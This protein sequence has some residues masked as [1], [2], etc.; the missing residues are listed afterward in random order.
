MT[1]RFEPFDPTPADDDRLKI[2][3]GTLLVAS[4]AL[5]GTVFQ[6]AVVFVLQNN[7]DGTF[8]VVLNRPANDEIKV[9]WHKLVGSEFSDRFIVQ[10]GPI[11]GPVF[12]LHQEQNLAEMEIPGGVFVSAGSDK[13]Q[14]LVE[15]D[16]SSYRIVFGVAGW[17]HGQLQDEIDDG[18]WFPLDGDAAQ[19]FDDPTWMWEKTLRRYGQELICDIVGLDRLP[20]SPLLN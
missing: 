20:A 16:D 12:A 1:N 5:K 17:Q 10:G 19:V 6:K 13:F 18:L 7:A 3:P 9:E 11:G 14:Q 15:N 8:G 2:A 4:P